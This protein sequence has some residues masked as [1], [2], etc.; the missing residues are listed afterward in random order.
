VHS[1]ITTGARVPVTVD[2]RTTGV[3][4]VVGPAGSTSTLLRWFLVQLGTLRSSP[5]DPRIVVI[6]STESDELA[7][8]AWLPTLTPATPA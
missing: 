1:V 4:G 6:T 8:T 2:L 5:D 3:L 7:W